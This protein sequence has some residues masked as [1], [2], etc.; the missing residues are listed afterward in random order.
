VREGEYFGFIDNAGLL[1]IPTQFRDVRQFS[2]GLAPVSLNHSWT[3]IDRSRGR[4]VVEKEFSRV[5]PFSGGLARVHLQAGQTS[6]LGYIDRSG[7][8]VWYPTN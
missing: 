7:N 8:Y 6:R 5:E 4:V 2:E 3:F 1:V